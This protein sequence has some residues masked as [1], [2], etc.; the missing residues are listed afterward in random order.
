MKVIPKLK[1]DYR[2]I[3]W[4]GVNEKFDSPVRLKMKLMSTS[5]EHLPPVSEIDSFEVGYLEGR[6]Q[7]KRWIV[8]D[9]DVIEMYNNA[10]ND[11]QEIL[12]WCDGKGVSRKRGCVN[13][14]STEEPVTKRSN[15][16]HEE[17]VEE[18]AQESEGMHGEKYTYRQYKL[19]GRMIVNKD[20]TDKM[21]PPNVPMIMGKPDKK[22]KKEFSECISDCAVAIVKALL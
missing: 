12:L 3:S 5:G 19:W 17:T 9:A 18:M 10:P 13:D 11:E 21:T 14:A 6:R 7:I 8:S 1:K 15:N 16:S 2:V 4:H 22:N 20:H